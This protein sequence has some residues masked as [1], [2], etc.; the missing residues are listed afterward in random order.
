MSNTQTSIKKNFIMNVILTMSSF[1]F[2]FITFPYIS[3][4]LL[5]TGTGKI[6]FVTSV[7]TYFNM[8]AQLGTYS[9]G[10]R[11]I[12]LNKDNKSILSKS[13]FE[14]TLMKICSTAIFIIIY[15][16]MFNV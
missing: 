15:L 12:A 5:P 9:Y 11:E 14:I 8:F 6:Q 7:V 1:I 4:I 13:F 2:P 10:V 3:R 16:Y